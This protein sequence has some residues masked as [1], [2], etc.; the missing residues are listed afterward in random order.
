MNLRYVNRTSAP[1][2]YFIAV[3][4]SLIASPALADGYKLPL[5]REIPDTPARLAESS[6]NGTVSLIGDAD[7]APYSF[8]SRSGGPAGLAVELAL[9]ACSEAK[10]RCEVKLM[11]FDQLLPALEQGTADVVISGPRLDDAARTGALVTRPWFRTM[12][13][14]AVLGG[15]PLTSSLAPA[16]SGKR[17]GVVKDTLHARWLETYYSTSEII[18][19]DDDARAR[20]ALRTGGVEAY[21]G[22]NLLTIYWVAGPSAQGCCRLLDGAYADFDHFSRSLAFLT[23]SGR[24]DLR[25]AFDA[26]LDA[27]QQKG[28]TE[29]IFNTYVPLSPW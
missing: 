20:D 4:L 11:S 8:V 25:A 22:D 26:G 9:A 12:A 18:T 5:F 17:I 27:A 21:F 29:K 7:F 1:W 16:L 19:F 28:V 10:L 24:D 6:G 3:A 14:F 13:R 15:S 23:G 2:V